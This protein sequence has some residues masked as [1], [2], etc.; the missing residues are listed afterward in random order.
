MTPFEFP[1]CNE[2]SS[3]NTSLK[4]SL[5]IIWIKNEMAQNCFCARFQKLENSFCCNYFQLSIK[6]RQS[7]SPIHGVRFEICY[8]SAKILLRMVNGKSMAG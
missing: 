6:H 4:L 5:Q 1:N 2:G 7:F 3:N 8:V